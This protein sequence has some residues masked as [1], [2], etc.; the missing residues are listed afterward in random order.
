MLRVRLGDLLCFVWCSN[1]TPTALAERKCRLSLLIGD[2]SVQSCLISMSRSCSWLQGT[3]TR[4]RASECCATLDGERCTLETGLFPEMHLIDLRHTCPSLHV[5]SGVTR[6]QS[7]QTVR[8]AP[9]WRL[10]MAHLRL[11]CNLVAAISLWCQA[12]CTIGGCA[13][14]TPLWL[15]RSLKTSCSRKTARALSAE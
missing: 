12:Y 5:A 3:L 7:A 8:L 14:T 11:C 6:Q 2:S 9:E 15:L 1:T 10:Y 4:V 13:Q